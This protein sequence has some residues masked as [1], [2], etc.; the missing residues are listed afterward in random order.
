MNVGVVGGGING[1]SC[2]WKIAELGHN[3]SIY[4]KDKILDATSSASSKLLHGGLR[5]L[6]NGEFL[7]VR[8]ALRERDAW[9]KRVPD[10]ARPIRLIMPIYRNARRS[11]WIISI[12]MTIYDNLSGGRIMNRAKYLT[13]DEVMFRDPN[14]KQNDLL[15][16]YEFSDGQMDDRELGYWVAKQA[17]MLGVSIFENTEI[18]TVDIDGVVKT[19]EDKIIKHDFIVN[20][21]GPWA[22]KLLQVSGIKKVPYKLDLIRGS[23]LV[24]S[25]SCKQGFLLEVPGEQRIFFVLPWKG[26]TLIGTTEVKQSIDDPIVC[27]G[28]EKEYLLNAYRYYYPNKDITIEKSYSGLRPLLKGR[29]NLS[30]ISRDYAIHKCGKLL[31]VFGG[32]WTTTLSL[33]EKV[34]RKI[35]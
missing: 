34:I 16:G 29:E 28:K 25:G 14:I 12:G 5:Y 2:A 23:H 9:I 8:E 32:K 13:P 30:K 22:E 3:V 1:L 35:N 20:V 31:T 19:S 11:G 6:E 27:S 15:G 4:E 21:A 33:A 24:L 10:I 26:K 7:L 17:E 18:K